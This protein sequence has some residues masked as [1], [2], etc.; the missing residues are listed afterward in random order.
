MIVFYAKNREA[1]NTPAT[2]LKRLENRTFQEALQVH[3]LLEGVKI[4]VK[5]FSRIH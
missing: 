1:H 2:F 4:R 5:M 3:F